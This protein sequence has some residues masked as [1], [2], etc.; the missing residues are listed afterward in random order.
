MSSESGQ[1]PEGVDSERPNAARVYDYYLGGSH[2]F[3]VDR[4]LGEQAIAR[5]PALPVIIQANRDFLRRAVRFLVDQGIRQFLDLGSGVPTVGNVHEIAQRAAQDARVV[6]VD[7][8]PI[9]V[10]YSKQLLADNAR[11]T[12]VQADLRD[13]AAVLA[14]PSVRELLDFDQP[15]AVL[16]VAVL[17]FVSD[18]NDPAGIVSAYREA[19]VAGSYIT[20]SHASQE[21]NK[22][23][24]EEHRELY[25]RTPTP[26]TMRTREEI[27]AL[28]SGLDLVE[29]GLVHPA[30]WRPDPARRP[31]MEPESLSGYAA[32][33]RRL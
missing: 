28:L 7:V 16:M 24:A 22:N 10:A 9:A 15:V 3:A 23:E 33:G 25:E 13:P 1:L 4:E 18:D 20:L 12:V 30:E 31:D 29:P 14:E 27:G 21:G 32:V 8:D 5:W 2:N 11:A 17:H 19:I 6:Y 26:M